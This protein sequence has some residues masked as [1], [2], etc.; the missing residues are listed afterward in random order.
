[1]GPKNPDLLI[2]ASTYIRGNPVSYLSKA[3]EERVPL[4]TRTE[5]VPQTEERGRNEIT[6]FEKERSRN[7]KLKN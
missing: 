2:E 5:R 6:F 4:G 7:E 3:L 1:M